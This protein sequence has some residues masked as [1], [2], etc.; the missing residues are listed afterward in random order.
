LTLLFENYRFRLLWIAITLASLGDIVFITVQ[1]WLTLD[2]TDSP[3][4]VGATMGM[5][6]VGM[7]STVAIGG[8]LADL[9]PRRSIIVFSGIFRAAALILLTQ[10][11]FMGDVQLWQI[12][13]TSLLFGISDAMRAPAHM[14]FV[15]DI[16]GEKRVLSANAANFVGLG[17]AGISA[18]LIMALIVNSFGIGWAYIFIISV[19]I[20]SVMFLLNITAIPSLP[21]ENNSRNLTSPYKTFKQGAVYIF[22]TNK[23]RNLIILALASEAFGWAHVSMLPVL[24]RDILNSGV[25]G[26]GYLQS[27]SFA[28]F[29]IGSFVISIFSDIKWKEIITIV[30][31]AGFSILI[32]ALSISESLTLS[33]VIIFAAYCF[34]SVGEMCMATLI[35]TSVP[36][37]MRGRVGS[38]QA[39][40][41]SINKLSSFYMGTISGLIGVQIAIA[42]SGILMLTSLIGVSRNILGSTSNELIYDSEN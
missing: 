8:V 31:S 9:L 42:G 2:I 29:F 3:F 11:I 22:S 30:G 21:T 1:G 25:S 7:I 27:A 35:Q 26:L 13:A 40:A 19:E 6:G 34:G 24:A 32:I 18:P 41:W 37:H 20:I 36:G 23:I 12:L 5:G 33:L 15:V 10:T 16:V 17:I 39:F 14:A 28:G 38:F 4:W